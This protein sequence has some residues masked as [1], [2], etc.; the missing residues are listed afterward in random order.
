[1]HNISKFIKTMGQNGPQDWTL[2]V[3]LQGFSIQF[4]MSTTFFIVCRMFFNRCKVHKLLQVGSFC[5]LLQALHLT[6]REFKVT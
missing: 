6:A 5:V 3:G 1:M 4:P 2:G